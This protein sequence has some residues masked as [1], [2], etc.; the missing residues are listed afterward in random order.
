MTETKTDGGP[1]LRTISPQF[2]VPDVV[3]A[4][5]YYRDRLGFRILGYFGE[6]PV[7]TIVGRDAVEIFL[8]QDPRVAGRPRPRA[9]GG[10]DAYIDVSGVDALAAELRSRGATIIEGPVDR[11]YDRREVVVEDCHGLIIAFG[12]EFVKRAA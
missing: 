12:E 11:V 10:Y 9:A 7:F 5:E 4:A 1:R 6:P 3:A 8:N 2:T